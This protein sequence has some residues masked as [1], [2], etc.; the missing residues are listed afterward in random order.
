LIQKKKHQNKIWFI[1][2]YGQYASRQTALQAIAE[3]PAS[4]QALKPWV[5][6]NNLNKP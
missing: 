5:R 4:L 1:L 3:M 6:P 2:T